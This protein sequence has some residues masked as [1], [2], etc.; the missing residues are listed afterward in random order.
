MSKLKIG[1]SNMHCAEMTQDNESGFMYKPPFY[2]ANLVNVTLNKTTNSATFFADNKP[3]EVATSYGGTKV[4]IEL[5]ELPPETQAVL[6]GHT[7]Q[8]G[9]LKRNANDKAPYVALMFEGLNADGTKTYVK[10]YKG[11]FQIPNEDYSTKKEQPEFKSTTIEADFI[12]RSY[13]GA[14][15]DFVYSDNASATS[16]IATWY[17]YVDSSDTTVIEMP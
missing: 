16:K 11:K 5:A 3:I 10:L 15:D 9:V 8:D 2:V 7:I 17:D 13:D 4:S 1:V 12:A 14:I 6:L